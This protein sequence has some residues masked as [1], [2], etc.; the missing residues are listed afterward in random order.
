MWIPLIEYTLLRTARKTLALQISSEWVL[1]VRAPKYLHV[2]V[3]EDFIV[4]KSDWIAKNQ[5]NLR[6]KHQRKK[7]Y[8]DQEFMTIK[9]ELSSYLESRVRSLHAPTWLPKYHSIKVT[10]SERRWGS[11]NSKNSL[12][13]SYRLYEFL[14]EDSRCIDAII[15]HELA[16]LKEKNHGK[17][18]WKIVYE[19]MPDY[20]EVLKQMR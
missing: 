4:R 14:W 12:C 11:C 5:A 8:S 10:K 16:H 7:V 2:S 18:F 20:D 6:E 3:I 15:Y 17:N 1:Y 19:L 9:M 13:F